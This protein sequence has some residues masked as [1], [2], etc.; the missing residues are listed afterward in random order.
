MWTV[1]LNGTGSTTSETN[2]RLEITQPADAAGGIFLTGLTSVCRVRGDFDIQVDFELST[3]P[4]QNGV[5]VG[6]V[7]TGIGNTERTSN[8][9]VPDTY[10][11]NFGDGVQG[12][13][14][15]TDL[16]GRLRVTRSGSSVTGFF[17]NTGT[18]S[19]VP[20]HTFDGATTG[21]VRFNLWSWSHDSIFADQVVEVAF[22]NAIVSEG[23]LICEF[24]KE[25][26]EDFEDDLSQWVGKGEGA[27]NGVIVEDPLRPGNHVL[28][29]TA[30][31]AGGD[32]FGSEV[33]VTPGQTYILM[34]D[35]LG[36]PDRGGQPGNLGGFVGFAEDTPGQHRWP[37]GT[38]LCCGGEDDPL[39][40]DGE[41]HTYSIVIDPFEPGPF[42]SGLPSGNTIRVML[43]DFSGSG[44]VAGDVFFDNIWLDIHAA[45]CVTPPSGLVSWW[46]GDGS[47]NDIV[48]LNDGTLQNG[49]TFAPGK[50][51]QAFSLDGTDDYVSVPDQSDWTLGDD[52]FTIDLWVN[53]K[54]IPIRA[55]F[56]DHNEGPGETNKWIFWY[57]DIGHRGPGGPALRFHINSPTL[58][59]LDPV[60]YPWMPR[61][62]R[63]YHVAVTR[64][65]SSYSLYL[66]GQKVI[67]ETDSNTIPDAEVELSIGQSEFQYFFNGLI[68]EVEII[69]RALSAS[70]IRDI[71]NAGSAGKCRECT[72]APSGL[73]SWWPGDGSAND[74]VDLNDGTLQNGAT[75][76]PGKIG[77]AFSFDGTGAVVV[78][79]NA[80]LNLQRFTI[81]AWVFPERA[82]GG[83]DSIL[84]KEA[85][86]PLALEDI[87]YE[88]AI[89]GSGFPGEGSIP[90]GNF[91]FFIGGISGLPDEWRGW[92]DGGAA[93]PLNEWS[94]V[95]LSFDG[96]TASAYVNG[97]L[98]RTIG[99]LSGSV[100]VTSG[101]LK[102]GSRSAPVFDIDPNLAF[103]GLIDEVEIF[104]RALSDSEI[105]DISNAGSAGKCR[106]CTPAPSG[107]VSWW[108]GDGNAGDIVSDNDGAPQNGATAD[109]GKVGQAFSLD[110]VDD[111]VRVSD[112]GS[113][114]I[115][116]NLTVEA[117]VNPE[118]DVISLQ[119]LVSKFTATGASTDPGYRLQIQ[120]GGFLFEVGDGTNSAA[121][122]SAPIAVA[123]DWFHVVGVRNTGT[124]TLSLYV[125]GVLESSVSDL[126][127]SPQSPN[128]LF[129]S[130]NNGGAE[131]FDGLIDEVSV[132][133]RALNASEIRAAFL[134]GS[135]GKCKAEDTTPP[136]CE[137]IG[138][139][140]AHPP[141]PTN[142]LVEVQ[143]TGS[144]L[145]AI[146][147]LVVKNAV[148]NIPAFSVGTTAVVQVVADKIDES[149]RSRVEIQAI[150]VAGNSSTCD[151]VLATLSRESGSLS[152][153]D[154]RSEERYL[155]IS[156]N[157]RAS[158]LVMANVN[159]RW[160]RAL[161]LD[162]QSVTI[163]LGSAMTDGL[164]NTVTLW[165]SSDTTILLA[166][167][168]PRNATISAAVRP[169]WHSAWSQAPGR[170]G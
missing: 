53:F 103:N 111:F 9:G 155:T 145:D 43:E 34:F 72:P 46:P 95:A 119:R 62:D 31:N 99:D 136:R 93:L 29:F 143:D 121:A 77:Q 85:D 69:D 149:K 54:E 4:T 128:D 13:T 60:V 70:E 59:P 134:A 113:L 5:R 75:F 153:R 92:V 123:G 36:L 63:W 110:G 101:P 74:I 1:E 26:H 16:S 14:P 98:T 114:G 168:A 45:V 40:D 169:W 130:S 83:A 106:E 82:D 100:P 170:G 51:G 90:V 140:V 8:P 150:D 15:T 163:D 159:G 118:T 78:A 65:G 25:F 122:V 127:V 141:T 142:L 38:A 87:Q 117:W 129:I 68:D 131:F 88:I 10:L 6:L 91:V 146:N 124:G 105:R 39:I 21:D 148:V 79:D 64:S 28:T 35:Y 166:D 17:F 161:G 11:T 165:A 56:V 162:Q 27:H 89:R 160:F 135:A 139:N 50:V 49:A 97:T 96:T 116:G 42:Y 32:V 132:Y 19:W 66:D 12:L 30:L 44:G 138:V 125:N 3:W 151:P 67:T 86:V 107:L 112:S 120:G 52:E 23:H 80:N 24:A 157:G 115:T 84:N 47:A 37:A 57:D 154:I 22:D 109:L 167:A 94:H 55:P 158:S 41:W 137:V 102:L 7:V 152:V 61:T 2:Q 20:I 73:V 144:G 81:D 164:E 58:G 71:F 48:D 104:D 33:M 108:P 126:T 18:D 147:G 156:P 133:S 76:A